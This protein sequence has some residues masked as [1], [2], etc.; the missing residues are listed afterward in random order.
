MRS[1]VLE[2]TSFCKEILFR[3]VAGN[4]CKHPNQ[5]ARFVSHVLKTMRYLVK[6]LGMSATVCITHIK[7]GCYSIILT[8][9]GDERNNKQKRIQVLLHDSPEDQLTTRT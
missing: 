1:F 9:N 2:K 4:E 7:K 6:L 8:N 3:K 5:W